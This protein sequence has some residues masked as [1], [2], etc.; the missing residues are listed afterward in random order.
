MYIKHVKCYHLEKN[1][2]HI[3]V[4]KT[5]LALLN[6]HLISFFIF[7]IKNHYPQYIIDWFIL[8]LYT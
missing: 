5:C 8:I 6:Y 4:N 3:L 7:I 2:K 1:M